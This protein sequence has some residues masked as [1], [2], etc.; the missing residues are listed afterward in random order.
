M[1]PMTFETLLSCF[2]PGS[3]KNVNRP[4]IVTAQHQAK[5]IA[6]SS[7][8]LSMVSIVRPCLELNM[9]FAFRPKIPLAKEVVA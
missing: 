1:E 8:V 2:L 9:I 5:G 6:V 3:L 4:V 7:S